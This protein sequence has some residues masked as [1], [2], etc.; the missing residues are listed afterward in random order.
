M[1]LRNKL[2]FYLSYIEKFKRPTFLEYVEN[3]SSAYINTGIVPSYDMTVKVKYKYTQLNSTFNPIFG[4]RTK[5][6]SEGDNLFWAGMH[7]TDKQAYLRFGGNS[8]NYAMGDDALDIIEMVASPDGIFINSI[9]TSARYYDGA[10]TPQ[11]IPIFL[12]TLNN[13]G[14]PDG[15]LGATNARVYSFEVYDG[16][17]V[18]IQNLRPALDPSGKVCMYDTVTEKYFYNAGTGELKAGGRFVES[19]YFD[20]ESYIDTLLLH[21][22]CTIETAVKYEAGH[23]R[24]MLTGWSG[25]GSYWGMMSNGELEISGSGVS[26]TDLTD[27][28]IVNIELDNENLLF[29]V[30][31]NSITTTKA[32]VYAD[33]TYTI[34]CT[35]PSSVNKIIGNVYYSKVHNASGELVQDLHPYVDSDGVA[36]FK[37]VVTDTLFYN[38]GTGTLTYTEFEILE[39]LE[40]DGTQYI[41]TGFIP[42]NNTK[43]VGSADFTQWNGSLANYVFGVFDSDKNFG[44][45][46]GSA[47]S[48]FNTLW[49]ASTGI[50]DQTKGIIPELNVKYNFDISKEG[51]YINDV[52]YLGASRFTA[53]F[54]AQ[55]TMFIGWS[56]GTSAQSMSGRIYP[57]KVY[58]NGVMVRDMIPVKRS[59]GVKCMYDKVE[60]KYYEILNK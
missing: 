4:M 49:G 38:Q 29:T 30:T 9:D 45:N 28:T 46:V 60:N 2:P 11:A 40:F 43:V 27:Y 35:T 1:N 6:S 15:G 36:C 52:E 42:S 24:R 59:D 41:D 22:T 3:T 50:N 56:N 33:S 25:S 19:I 8:T 17:G 58:D 48:F 16:N 7:Y 55:K 21:Q 20:G 51:S 5:T 18:L 34:G 31:V 32:A 57:M 37:D 47:R 10:M 53:T 26:G 39:C 12:F 14:V 54:Q 44:F 13:A 23:S